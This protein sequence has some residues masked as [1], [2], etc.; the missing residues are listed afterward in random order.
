MLH[1]VMR[2]GVHRLLMMKM[3]LVL[4][5]VVELVVVLWWRHVAGRRTLMSPRPCFCS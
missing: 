4:I 3:D 1:R 5:V 2:P